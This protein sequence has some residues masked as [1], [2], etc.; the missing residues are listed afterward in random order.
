MIVGLAECVL[1]EFSGYSYSRPTGGD[2]V[3][4]F[5]GGFG[6]GFGGS[7]D[8]IQISPGVQTNEGASV[9]RTLL[10]YVRQIIL[11]EELQ[12]QSIGG[13]GGGEGG[14]Y[15]SSSYGAPSPQ[16]GV[17]SP[18]YGVPRYQVRVTDVEFEDIKQGNQVA[19]F[20][21]VTQERPGGFGA[22]FQPLA[23]V[24]NRQASTSGVDTS[25]F[26]PNLS[27]SGRRNRN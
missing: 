16:Y 23:G 8:Y 12:S 20:S 17:P 15:P 27:R 11:K 18:Q 9:D 7:G 13:F 5:G 2:G 4:S 19:Q 1:A 10:E 24:P 3:G 14:R 6:G 26:S 25:I 21:Q 22:S